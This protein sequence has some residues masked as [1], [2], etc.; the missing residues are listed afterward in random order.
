MAEGKVAL[1]NI[2]DPVAR[3]YHMLTSLTQDA[4]RLVRHM[5]HEDTDH[6]SYDNLHTSLL[7]SHSLSN[8]QKTEKMMGLP[9]LGNRKLS[10]MLVEMLECCL[11]GESETH[12]FHV[13]VSP[14]SSS[15]DSCS[16]LEDDPA[17]MR[18]IADKADCLIAM[19]VPQG[20]DACAAVSPVDDSEGGLVAATSGGRRKK[21][22]WF[23]SDLS[24]SSSLALGSEVAPPC[25]GANQAALPR[26]SMCFYHAKF[27]EQ[28]K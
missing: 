28:A 27:G 12:R 2:K 26:T 19:H 23:P 10:V 25:C 5:L 16:A 9:P 1:R 14:G 11:A 3:Y 18:A 21:K 17:D 4:V 15:G 6:N 7:S 13:F 8:Y 24:S 22:S 20:H